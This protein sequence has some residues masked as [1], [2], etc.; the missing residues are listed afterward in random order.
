MRLVLDTNTVISGLLWKGAE[1]TLIG[2]ARDRP[3]IELYS[4]PRLLAEFADVIGRGKFAKVIAAIGMSVEQLLP[5]YLEIV[6]VVAPA[7]VPAVVSEDPDDDHVLACAI[8]AQADLIVSGD[9][10]LLKL[11][12][13]RG[14][15]IISTVEALDRI[16]KG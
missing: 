5:R 11:N 1:R 8:A 15:P 10:A 7:N 3:D 6:R 2:V 12:S 16:G 14:I 13:Y 4:S 9:S